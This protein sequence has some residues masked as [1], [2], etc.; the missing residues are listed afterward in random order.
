MNGVALGY[1]LD[2]RCSTPGRDWKFFFSPLCSDR[3]WVPPSLPWVSG[4][5]SLGVKLLGRDA[6]HSTPPS[7]DVKNAWSY[8]ST[9]QYDLVTWC[10]VKKSTETN[11]PFTFHLHLIASYT[12][13]PRTYKTCSEKLIFLIFLKLQQIV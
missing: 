3:L 2:D 11:L 8:T 7:V 4:I 1:G 13:S 9:P 6:D 5:L 10:S 12:I